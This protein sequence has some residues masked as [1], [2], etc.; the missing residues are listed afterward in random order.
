MAK[1]VKFDRLKTYAVA[2]G[3]GKDANTVYFTS[4]TKQIV[5]NGQVYGGASLPSASTSVLGGVKLGSDTVIDS[6]AAK[7][8][9]IQVNS[10]GQMFVNVPWENTTYTL[11]GLM[12][13]SAKGS[14]TQPIYWTGSAFASTSYSL[15]KSVPSNAVFTDT[16]QN[17]TSSTSKAFLTGV[18][19][20]PTST[21]QALTGVANTGVFMQSGAITA[22]GG[23]FQSSDIRKKNVLGDLSL[24]KAY[25]LIDKCQT[26]L[27]TM[28]DDKSS[29]EQIGLI[30]QEV[31]AFFPEI[32]SVDD[33]GFLSLDYARLTVVILKVLKDLISRISA[34]EKM[35]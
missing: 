7:T 31:Q 19:T 29:K 5:V 28:K 8:Y 18:T 6:T 27:Y 13:S 3:S 12:G 14:T 2:T 9:A 10:S 25:D 35:K 15:S 24:D 34:L 16:K 22:S 32:V 11:A 26:I 1:N 30:A 4:D 20:S 33:N 17:I 23:F 21:A